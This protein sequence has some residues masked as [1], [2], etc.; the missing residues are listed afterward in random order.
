MLHKINDREK[1]KQ[2]GGIVRLCG[3]VDDEQ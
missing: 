3:I 2:E 1:I